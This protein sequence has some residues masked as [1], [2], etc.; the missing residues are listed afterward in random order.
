MWLRCLILACLLFLWLEGWSIDQHYF[1]RVETQ[2]TPRMVGAFFGVLLFFS[3]LFATL[4]SAR[5]LALVG[6]L[7]SILAMLLALLP[8]LAA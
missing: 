1:I 7:I 4:G 5:R 8:T 6:I 3:S 2:G